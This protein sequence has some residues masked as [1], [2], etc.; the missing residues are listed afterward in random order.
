[1]YDVNLKMIYRNKCFLIISIW[2]L[3]ISEID[4]IWYLKM[5]MILNVLPIPILSHEKN[6]QSSK[7]KP[8]FSLQIRSYIYFLQLNIRKRNVIIRRFNSVL[9]HFVWFV[10]TCYKIGQSG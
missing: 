1:M 3:N 8:F 7:I 6:Q 2:V 10:W 9:Q 5:F 4:V